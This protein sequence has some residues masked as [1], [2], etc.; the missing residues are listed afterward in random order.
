[1]YLNSRMVSLL[2]Y[3]SHDYVDVFDVFLMWASVN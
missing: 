3:S 1:M 2:I